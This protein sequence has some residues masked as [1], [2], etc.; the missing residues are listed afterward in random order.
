[1]GDLNRVSGFSRKGR[2]ERKCSGVEWKDSRHFALMLV[3]DD[4]LYCVQLRFTWF[5]V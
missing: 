5:S 1:M 4:V 3:L 2:M